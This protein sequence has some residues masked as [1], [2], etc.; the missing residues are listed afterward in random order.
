M[1]TMKCQFAIKYE[2]MRY[3]DTQYIFKPKELLKGEETEDGFLCE[4]GKSYPMF[5]DTLDNRRKYYVDMIYSDDELSMIYEYDGDDVDF[6]GEYFFDSYK[7]TI[8]YV[9]TTDVNEAG[10]PYRKM[11][12]LDMIDDEQATAIYY[13]DK[14]I[15]NVVLNEKAIREITDCKKLKQI[16]A[17]L[18]KYQKGLELIKKRRETD[19]VTRISITGNKVNYFETTRDIDFDELEEALFENPDSSNVIFE[20]LSHEVSYQGLR[21]YIK[22]RVFGHES[23]IDTFAQKLYMNYT[24]VEGEVI[25]SILLV[26]PTGTGKTETVRAACNYLG[27][28]MIEFNASNLNAEGIVGTSIESLAIALYDSAGGDLKKAERGIVFLDEFDKLSDSANLETKG[29]VKNILLTFTGG[30]TFPINNSHYNFVFDSTMTNKIYAGVFDRIN[31]KQNPIG[32]SSTAKYVPMLGSAEEVREKIIEK[33]YYTQE[34]LSRITTL[35]VY[36]ELDKETKRDILLHSKLSEY[37]KKK[38]RY[39]RQFGIDLVLDDEYIEAVLNMQSRVSTGMRVVNNSVKR[40]IDVAERFILENEDKGY[41][42]LILT[43]DTV[44]NPKNFD[45]SK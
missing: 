33:K 1:K 20:T 24:A 31:E 45:L 41:K 25:E 4:N 11:I 28:P 5:I 32:F 9:D 44:N 17:V 14:N 7:N 30:G 6:I 18:T 36:D 43:R 22:E 26:G 19:G 42:K 40:T 10:M 29:P 2:I 13:M 16:R 27:L 8:M 37:L 3:S 35:L 12:N 38:D 34:E 15:P 23:E 39:K 21:N